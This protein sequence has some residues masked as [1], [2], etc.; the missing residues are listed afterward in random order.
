MCL[1]MLRERQRSYE[2]GDGGARGFRYPW[3]KGGPRHLLCEY[4]KHILIGYIAKLAQVPLVVVR[5]GYMPPWRAS[6]SAW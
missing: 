1:H 2:R 6:E 4:K 3:L 5:R